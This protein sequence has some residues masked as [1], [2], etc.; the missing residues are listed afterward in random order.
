[1]EELK[2][3]EAELIEVYMDYVK[4]AKEIWTE[5]DAVIADEMVSKLYRKYKSKQIY[6]ERLIQLQKSVVDDIGVYKTRYNK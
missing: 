2:Y 1:M 5:N 4:E 6:L 3:L